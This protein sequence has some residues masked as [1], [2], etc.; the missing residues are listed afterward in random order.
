MRLGTREMAFDPMGSLLAAGLGT[1]SGILVAALLSL[2]G[3]PPA[4]PPAPP[5]PAYA[6][7]QV[8]GDATDACAAACAHLQAL[9]CPE[10]LA[11]DCA[12]VLTKVETDRLLSS[13]GQPL[14]CAMV[15]GAPS[16]AQEQALHLC[17]GDG[18]P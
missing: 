16:V 14:T 17:A 15:L 6:D 13:D 8:I 7:V 5:P 3:C 10:G 1:G 12:V 2:P 11:A 4:S 9:G 18:S